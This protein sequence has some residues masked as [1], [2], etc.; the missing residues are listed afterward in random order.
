MV[1]GAF[2]NQAL[3]TL[4]NYGCRGM[5]YALDIADADYKSFELNTKITHTIACHSA[6]SIDVNNEVF[7][8][9]PPYG[10]AVNFE[11]IL[12][13]F[14]AWLRRTRRRNSPTGS[15]TAAVRSQ[16]KA[17]TR[18]SAEAWWAPTSA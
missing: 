18:I 9:D 8:T 17:R 4:I 5:R 6:Q 13:F 10:D 15:G 2:D 12:D 7:V 11:E 14:I 3:N 16:S 1:T